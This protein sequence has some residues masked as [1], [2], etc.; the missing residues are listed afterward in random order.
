MTTRSIGEAE[1]VCNWK[2]ARF[3]KNGLR[4]WR[5]LMDV[6]R[7]K[8]ENGARMVK[9]L[10]S[11]INQPRNQFSVL[12]Q[13]FMEKTDVE[14]FWINLYCTQ[15]GFFKKNCC[16]SRYLVGNLSLFKNTKWKSTAKFHLNF[17]SVVFY[18]ITRLDHKV[19]GSNLGTIKFSVSCTGSD[20]RLRLTK[21]PYVQTTA[22]SM[23]QLLQKREKPTHK[24]P[25]MFQLLTSCPT[26]FN[27]HS[28]ITRDSC[29]WIKRNCILYLKIN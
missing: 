11:I 22:N 10:Q 14:H 12:L 6:S 4:R 20:A 7:Q 1:P 19:P 28:R 15:Y 17:V 16:H 26:V 23:L 27:H 21:H 18:T 29:S 2:A 9:K 5:R 13:F 3:A 24:S 25:T 8:G